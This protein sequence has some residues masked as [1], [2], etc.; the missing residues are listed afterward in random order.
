MKL[1]ETGFTLLEMLVSIAVGALLF[2]S[3]GQILVTVQ[4][5]WAR[6]NEID[7]RI[8]DRQMLLTVLSRAIASALPASGLH[9]A[10]AFRGTPSGFEFVSLPPQAASGIGPV[11]V[12]V[13][14]DPEGDGT[15]RLAL[16][17]EPRAGSRAVQA[18][19]PLNARWV[20]AQGLRS[21]HIT[22]LAQA[23]NQAHAQWEDPRALPGLVEIV[24]EYDDLRAP[25]LFAAR[26]R[27]DVP[28]DCAI[29]WT[30]LAC[31]AS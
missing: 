16:H 31:R 26:P 24:G 14:V 19:A 23:T 7:G 17:I 8:A 30:S 5:G 13:I 11:R 25:L 3:L 2:A 9:P 20:L 6:S 28:G 1:R 22:Y 12:R 15:Q 27:V 21:V 10:E 4:D 29:D 18:S